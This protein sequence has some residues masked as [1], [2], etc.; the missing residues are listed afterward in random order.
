MNQLFKKLMIY[1]LYLNLIVVVVVLA[2]DDNGGGGESMTIEGTTTTEASEGTQENVLDVWIY[3]ETLCPDSHK[4]FREQL[5]PTWLNQ[6]EN[7]KLNLVPYG[8]AFV[9]LLC[10]TQMTLVLSSFFLFLSL[11]FC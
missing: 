5:Y 8:K 11:F 6:K 2:N 4:F 10:S 3:Y 1:L 9:S 7:M